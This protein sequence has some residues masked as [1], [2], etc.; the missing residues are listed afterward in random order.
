LT[1]GCD[2]I[3]AVAS[4]TTS[5]ARSKSNAAGVTQSGSASGHDLWREIAAAYAALGNTAA[6]AAAITEARAISMR[7][8]GHLHLAAL[9]QWE[10]V[11]TSPAFRALVRP[12]PR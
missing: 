5:P 6:A 7:E 1:S 2:W 4:T 3:H 11:R 10:P 8:V 12:D 9:P